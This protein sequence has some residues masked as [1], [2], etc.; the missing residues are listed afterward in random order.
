MKKRDATRAY[1]EAL[2]KSLIPGFEPI[3]IPNIGQKAFAGS[4]TI[5]GETHI[6]LGALDGTLI[7]GATLAG[8]DVTP[9][10]I[11]NLVGLARAEAD[12]ADTPP[13]RTGPAVA[14]A[15]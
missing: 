12:K 6:G 11:T 14:G 7:V 10:N 8:F 1:Q 4:V 9:D 5:G 15:A 2:E 13:R 3:A